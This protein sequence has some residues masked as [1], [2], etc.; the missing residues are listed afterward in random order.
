M[1]QQCGLGSISGPGVICGLS[2]LLV[3]YS[4]LR[5]FSPGTPV[6]P[7]PHWTNISKFESILECTGISERVLVNSLVLTGK[8]IYERSYIWLNCEEWHEDM[9]ITA[10]TNHDHDHVFMSQSCCDLVK[11]KLKH[12]VI[13]K[14]FSWQR[15]RHSFHDPE[16]WIEI[17]DPTKPDKWRIA[18][19]FSG[20]VTDEFCGSSSF[21]FC[22]LCAWFWDENSQFWNST[23]FTIRFYALSVYKI[24][25]FSAILQFAFECSGVF[26]LM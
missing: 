10:M 16:L 13:S 11:T 24:T 1:F 7:S 12:S 14:E 9:I 20:R 21:M 25:F 18:Q 23:Y 15:V 5:G 8:P 4:D 22:L 3:L 17:A 19:S 2:L 26:P 6:F